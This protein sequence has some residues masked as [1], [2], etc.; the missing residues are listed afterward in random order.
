MTVIELLVVDDH[1]LSR[2]GLRRLLADETDMRVV[3][4]T[5]S[6]AEALAKLRVR[7]FDVVLLDINLPQRSGLEVLESI[8]ASHPDQAVIMLSMYPEAQFALGAL[9]AG[10]SGYVAKDMEADELL[11]AIRR[12]ASG[13]RYVS[14]SLAER[15]II[16][17]A[18]DDDR[19]PHQ[20]LSAREFQVMMSLVQGTGLTEIGHQ[21]S[22][23]VKTVSTYR[24]RILAKLSEASNADL[25]RY[26]LRHR[27]ID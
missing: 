13:G 24:T 21:M 3:D 2:G 23:S 27:L 22:L 19:P 14:A 11:A 9:R 6:G 15:A 18:A 1:T 26:A 8:R 20:R 12:V 16:G 10:A 4:E 5:G 7:R 25:V 17:K